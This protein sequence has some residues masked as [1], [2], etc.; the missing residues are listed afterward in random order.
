M[1]DLM[2][3]ITGTITSLVDGSA[4]EVVLYVAQPGLQLLA[5]SFALYIIL[6]L[7][8]YLQRFRQWA[9]LYAIFVGLLSA[10]FALSGFSVYWLVLS[11]IGLVLVSVFYSFREVFK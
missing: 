5:S 11:L 2:P 8:L 1:G 7:W 10:P 4:H 9:L 3:V 6:I